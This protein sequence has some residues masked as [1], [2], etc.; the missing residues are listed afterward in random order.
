MFT[1]GGISKACFLRVSDNM[2]PGRTLL[3]VHLGHGRWGP[4]GFT[5]WDLVAFSTPV[6]TCATWTRRA[7][8][9]LFWSPWTLRAFL[10][11]D[12]VRGPWGPSWIFI[13]N[14]RVQ[15]L[16]CQSKVQGSILL[17]TNVRVFKHRTVQE[18]ISSTW[19]WLEIYPRSLIH[20]SEYF[21]RPMK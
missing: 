7:F 6:S 8:P 15:L 11:L 20:I 14:P 12:L 13:L 16:T 5:T 2:G 21:S 1:R 3:K 10:F 9:S 18:M 19:N 17:R 4:P